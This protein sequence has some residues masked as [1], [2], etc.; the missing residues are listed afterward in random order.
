MEVEKGRKA[1][2]IG[3]VGKKKESGKERGKEVRTTKV[4]LWGFP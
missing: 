2:L 1:Q 4:S 3:V